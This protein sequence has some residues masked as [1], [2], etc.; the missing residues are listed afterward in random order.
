[1]PARHFHDVPFDESTLAK[2]RL[3]ELYAQA[4]LPV[5]LSSPQPRWREIHLFDFFAGPG[6]DSVGIDG[7]PLRLLRQLKTFQSLPG[8]NVVDISVHFFD[9]D[10]QKVDSLKETIAK[11]GL[12]MPR[13]GLHI[14]PLKFSDAF[15][16][17]AHILANRDAAKLVFIDQFGVDKVT[18]G[19]F[20]QLVKSPTCDFIFF[21]SSSILHR[22]REHPA[23]KQK[24]TRPDDYFDVHRAALNYYRDLLPEPRDYYLAPFSMKK[25]SNIYGLIFG[26]GH[27][28]G[29]DKFLE[30]AWKEDS[31]H[32]EANFDID[33]E[34]ATSQQPLLFQVS[35][36]STFEA[37]LEG[38]IL[39][40]TV[41]NEA[42]V[43][44]VCFDHGVRRQHAQPVLDELK[45]DGRIEISFRVPQISK[46]SDPRLIKVR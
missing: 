1:M 14:E 15:L 29:M 4:W 46:L 10:P 2:L 27:P 31:I 9:A 22:F 41:R 6:K 30:V 42:D 44:R 32:G 18:D 23:I 26:S 38:L 25:G 5:F 43:V 39:N 40:G 20:Q 28:R 16:Q 37:E 11:S 12:Q 8:W 17:S 33:R 21:L 36:L 35:K 24:I 7:S 34:N 13:V 45:K 19:V 3:Y